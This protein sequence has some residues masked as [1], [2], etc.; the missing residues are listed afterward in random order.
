[1]N[2][3]KKLIGHTDIFN[4]LM[5]LHNKKKLPKKILLSG[6]K[7]IGKSLLVNKFL[8]EVYNESKL[9]TGFDELIKNNI[10]PNIFTVDKEVEKKNIDI[11]QVRDMIKF[12]NHSSFN[13]KEKFVFIRNAESLNTNSANALLKSL[14][15]PTNNSFFLITYDSAKKIQDTIKSRCLEFKLSL[16]N[17]EVKLI[18]DQFFNDNIYN[19]I[20]EDYIN[21]YN[22]PSFLIS[23]VIHIKELKHELNNFYIEDLLKE[24]IK[25]KH[26]VKNSF[27]KDNLNF[28]IELYFYKNIN[29][30]NN[31]TNKLRNYFYIK[32]SEIK[33]FNLDLESFFLEFEDKLLS[34]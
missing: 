32:F 21:Y 27:I 17:D 9:Q 26:Y 14:E 16:T 34:E 7:G 29:K 30:S 13:N 28:F 4:N 25:N 20:C 22:S 6:Q 8:N 5:H 33:K 3:I 15:E 1:M 18:V 12:L 19:Q 31:L 11:N 23:L 24:I 2:N 10:H